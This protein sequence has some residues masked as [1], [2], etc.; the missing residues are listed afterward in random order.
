MAYLDNK[1]TLKYTHKIVFGLVDDPGTHDYITYDEMSEELAAYALKTEVPSKTS[2]LTNDTHFVTRNEMDAAIGAILD[3]VAFE[4]DIPVNLSELNNDEGF[5]TLSD[6]PAIPTK[7]S[8][9]TNDSGFI[10]LSDIPSIPTKTSDLTNDSGFLTTAVTSF[11]GS[12]GAITY[13]APV[14][15]VNGQTG[16]VSIDTGVTSFNGS[17]GAVTYTAPVTS[18]NGQTGVVSIDTGVT[19]FN[20]STGAITY[21]APVT[22]VNGQTG[23]VT[24][25]SGGVTVYEISKEDLV[26]DQLDLETAFQNSEAY[27]N[28]V[29]SGDMDCKLYLEI[30]GG[31]TFEEVINIEHYEQE[32]QD[33]TY[34][35][36][37]IKT[38]YSQFQIGV[39]DYGEGNKEY[40]VNDYGQPYSG[41]TYPYV[42]YIS[43]DNLDANTIDGTDWSVV[44]S[45]YDSVF[46]SHNLNSKLYVHWD[47]GSDE[48]G[49]I[50]EVISIQKEDI[51]EN[52]ELEDRAYTIL[53]I[54]Y[55]YEFDYDYVNDVFT[56]ISKSTVCPTFTYNS[57]T[58]S[59]DI[60]I[61]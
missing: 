3:D 60:T 14:T 12:T 26:Y 10:T 22:S 54:H 35:T 32:E 34:S 24:V 33:H 17:T 51:V 55:R 28:A 13:T 59:L 49:L 36:Y 61:N 21:T 53:T 42:Y 6:I 44:E 29:S 9:L 18:V 5:I 16:V 38:L 45:Y 43:G 58:N 52:G 31:V 2:D 48:D 50:E 40:F 8:D 19:S 57:T 56:L 7:T 11:N 37:D 25:Q 46:V 30:G 39:Y 20:G 15:S 1:K 41:A 47:G 27:Y 23:A 4:E